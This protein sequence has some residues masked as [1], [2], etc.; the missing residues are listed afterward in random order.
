MATI[1]VAGYTFYTNS[2]EQVI[3]TGPGISGGGVNLGPLESLSSASF[4]AVT[5]S[6]N[7]NATAKSALTTISVQAPI[8][9]SQLVAQNAP[10]QASQSTGVTVRE[11]QVA[12]DEKASVVNPTG[13]ALVFKDGRIQNAADQRPAFAQNQN[14]GLNEPTKTATNTQ[15]TPPATANP[16]PPPPNAGGPVPGQTAGAAAPGDDNTNRTAGSTSGVRTRIDELFGLSGGQIT[17]IPTKPNKLSQYASYTYNVSVYLTNKQQYGRLISS[18][19]RSLSGSQLLMRSGGAPV[20]GLGNIDPNINAD[21]VAAAVAKAQETAGRNQFFDVDYYLDDIQLE[22]VINGKGTANSH[23]VVKLNFKVIEPNGISFLTRL[24]QAVKQFNGAGTQGQNYASQIYL[25]VIRFYGYDENGQPIKPNPNEDRTNFTDS[26]A[27]VEKFIPFMFTS[28]KFRIQ[29]RLTEYVCEAVCPQNLQ[30]S[31]QQRGVIPFNTEFTSTGLRDLLIGKQGAATP[32][33]ATTTQNN[34]ATTA[35]QLAAGRSVND[36]LFDQRYQLPPNIAVTPGFAEASG[37]PLVGQT[38]ANAPPKADAI[39]KPTVVTG[40]C[41]AL[42]R[43]Q[44]EFVK[45]GYFNYADEYRVVFTDSIIASASIVAPGG[46]DLK[47]P[48]MNQGQTAADKT[49]PGKQ[50][51]NNTA[52]RV[53]AFAGMSIVQFIDQQIRNSTYIYDQQLFIIDPV[54][55]EPK[56]Q[57]VPGKILGWYR[58]GMQVEP[59]E[60]DEKRNDYAYRIT[61]Q[62][63]PYAVNDVKSTFFP[64]APDRGAHKIYQYW[65][66]G[67]NSEILDYSQDYNYLY[68]IVINNRQQSF[69]RVV[70][71]R[72]LEKKGFQP[73]S[74]QSNQGQAGNV[75]E[76]SANAA[77]YLYSP[78]D[79]ARARL[80]ILGDPDWIQQGEIWSG[81]Q[82]LTTSPWVADDGSINYE[83]QEPLFRIFFNTP[84]DYDLYSG[85]MPVTQKNTG[86]TD[87]NAG[88]P[89]VSFTYRAITVTSNFSRGKFTQDIEGVLI[90]YPVPTTQA[91]QQQQQSRQNVNQ[92]NNAASA[93]RKWTVTAGDTPAAPGLFELELGQTN[94]NLGGR[95]GNYQG[96]AQV[97][98]DANRANPTP[99]DATRADNQRTSPGQVNAPTSGTQ[100]VGRSF[101]SGTTNYATGG[102]NPSLISVNVQLNDGSS[103]AATS[104]AEITSLY[105]AGLVNFA[106]AN[107]AIVSLQS[108]QNATQ[109]AVLN[110]N[111]QNM[112]I[113][114]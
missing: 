31:G 100:T 42:N 29:N 57:G 27:I 11:D 28:I 8:I 5:T 37:F 74:N 7:A 73:N 103:R 58:I 62:I 48:P 52:K 114:R 56:P 102:N 82:G 16:G 17:Q 33:Q 105:N 65:F 55:N 47:T 72:D 15:S 4:F 98:D 91:Q 46:T 51:V 26:N 89:A 50:S 108:K 45:K 35:Q 21:E 59:L 54:T 101:I 24:S 19:K 94:S 44:A 84:T 9:K 10:G 13:P 83:S 41:E 99:N 67:Q 34:T 69:N 92:R 106:Q 43:Y 87:N 25:M 38:S 95:I 64:T 71:Y 68:Y 79:L 109:A 63:S 20:G 40:L 88:L 39:R 3:V 104:V 111:P 107:S 85:T 12:N 80:S 2:S 36:I 78:A 112:K 22:S 90:T 77:D 61:Y 93:N 86:R 66:T 32:N 60:Y 110:S 81:L 49:L 18:K 76:P 70:D 23:N 113:E 96:L 1:I 6:P 14:S 53:N 30:A 97:L 75:N